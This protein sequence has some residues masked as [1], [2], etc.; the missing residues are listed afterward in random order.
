[1]TG[2]KILTYRPSKLW[3]TRKI[4]CMWLTVIL[5]GFRFSSFF[6]FLT[7]DCLYKS[8]NISVPFNCL[9]HCLLTVITSV[10][11]LYTFSSAFHVILN[12]CGQF[13][14]HN[15]LFLYFCYAIFILTHDCFV[16]LRQIYIK[17]LIVIF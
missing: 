12:K 17:L 14:S 16:Y 6:V 1:M 8:K 15:F 5:Q 3:Q 7:C 13:R 4:D 10:T 11:S 2:V 9:W